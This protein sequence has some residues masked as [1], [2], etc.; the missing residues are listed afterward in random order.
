MTSIEQTGEEWIGSVVVSAA[1]VL[2]IQTAV[3]IYLQKSR[4]AKFYLFPLICMLMFLTEINT[5]TRIFL[6]IFYPTDKAFMITKTVN[7]FLYLIAK[8]TIL[9]LAR[10]RCKSVFKPWGKYPWLHFSFFGA[11]VAQIFSVFIGD[12]IYIGKCDYNMKH[13]ACASL[14]I[15]KVIRD[16]FAP[17]PRLYYMVSETIF[18]IVLFRALKN[19]VPSQGQESMIRYRRFQAVIFIIDLGFIMTMI[20]YRVINIFSTTLPTYDYIDEFFT[21]FTV[22]NM[23]QFGLT[24][25]RLFNRNAPQPQE[26]VSSSEYEKNL[27]RHKSRDAITVSILETTTITPGIENSYHPKKYNTPTTPERPLL[28]EYSHIENNNNYN[29]FI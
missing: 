6:L 13:P 2:T 21:A 7:D 15:L 25:P 14:S 29:H 18:F 3:R 10:L 20:V 28:R 11:R 17:L 23:T 1:L 12:I 27:K 24:L 8:P 19:F 4:P 5:L 22:F 26:L 9:Y 16:A